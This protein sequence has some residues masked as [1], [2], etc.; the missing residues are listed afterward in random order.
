MLFRSRILEN[1]EGK[2]EEEWS[3]EFRRLGEIEEE[4][5]EEYG[6]EFGADND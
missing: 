1:E 2:S 5:A 4:L 3:P 6:I